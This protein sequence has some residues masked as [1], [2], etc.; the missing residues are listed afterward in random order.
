MTDPADFK[1][2]VKKQYEK[3]VSKFDTLD[4]IENNLK[5]KT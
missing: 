3:Y 2:T 5:K 4:Q 1:N